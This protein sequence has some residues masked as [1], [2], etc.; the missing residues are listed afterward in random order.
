M[1]YYN[2]RNPDQVNQ[3]AIKLYEIIERCL[4]NDYF[5]KEFVYTI[6]FRTEGNYISCNC[7][8]FELANILCY[9]IFKMLAIKDI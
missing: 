9:H 8:K 1:V 7:R 5:M 2:V 4:V 3:G 6:D